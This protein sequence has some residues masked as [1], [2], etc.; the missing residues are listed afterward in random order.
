MVSH[1]DLPDGQRAVAV[2]LVAKA[3]SRIGSDLRIT[4]E[5]NHS[6]SVIRVTTEFTCE[7]HSLVDKLCYIRWL[8]L[9]IELV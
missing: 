8:S 7:G 6:P 2:G 5:P 9:Q 3:Y 4:M 1:A